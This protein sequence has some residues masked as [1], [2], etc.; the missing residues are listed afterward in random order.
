MLI[1]GK[2]ELGKLI[3]IQVCEGYVFTSGCQ[4]VHSGGGEFRIQ[5]GVCMGGG[6]SASRG[7]G[8]NPPQSD[9]TEYG[10]TGMHSCKLN[11]GLLVRMDKFREVMH[12]RSN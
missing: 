12:W 8:Q 7:V 2:Y 9:T 10:H 3:L 6:S 5:E 1:C 11:L 4:S